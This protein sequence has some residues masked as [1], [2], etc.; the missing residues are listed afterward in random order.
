MRIPLAIVVAVVATCGVGGAWAVPATT[1][2]GRVH[3]TSPF[4]RL[5]KRQVCIGG[6]V[7][8]NLCVGGQW[9]TTSS[10]TPTSTAA[11]PVPPPTSAA[12]AT[13]P[14]IVTAPAPSPPPPPPPP[15]QPTSSDVV[16]PASSTTAISSSPS[17]PHTPT[18]TSSPTFILPFTFRSTTTTSSSLP[19]SP[20]SPTDQL[21]TSSNTQSRI[22][23]LL[24][25]IIGVCAGVAVAFLVIIGI[26][27]WRRRR[28][29]LVVYA[30][31]RRSNTPPPAYPSTTSGPGF[32]FHRGPAR[33][34]RNVMAPPSG[35]ASTSGHVA[36]AGAGG[37]DPPP[38]STHDTWS[39]NP[40]ITVSNANRRTLSFSW[41]RSLG[42]RRTHLSS[43]SNNANNNN[44]WGALGDVRGPP[45]VTSMENPPS[46]Q[47]SQRI[48]FPG[49]PATAMA[50]PVYPASDATDLRS[51]ELSSDVVAWVNEEGGVQISPGS[52]ALP[53]LPRT[54]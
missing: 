24:P 43:H 6:L 49:S 10:A 25:I 28:K 21:M 5:H 50:S 23:N 26:V 3:D 39:W 45:G 8:G 12:P 51:T 40:S 38:S 17:P 2:D 36:A 7:I 37:A 48:V 19:P 14:P 4:R 32:E 44:S 41:A 22:P 30:P 53:T 9:V 18:S 34:G 46:V 11:P 1:T 16:A 42:S 33:D 27:T 54:A 47:M 31:Y 52:S 15:A 35:G 13:T 29:S 20:T